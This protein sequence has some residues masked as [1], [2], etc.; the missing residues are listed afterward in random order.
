MNLV[1]RVKNILLSPRTEWPKIAGEAATV[2][3]LYT[4]YILILA[5]IAPIALLIRSGGAA[6]AAA[7]AQYIVALV[8]IYL[9]ALIADA[10]A[11]TFNGTKDFTQSL[12]LVAYSYTAPWIAGVFLLLGTTI[13]G[14]IGLL[15][16]IYAWYTFYLGVPALKKCPPEKAVGYT[17]VVVLCGI[18]LA[19]VLGVVLMSVMFGGTMG[20]AGVGLVR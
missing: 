9:L 5:A 20:G 6:I 13:G 4:G 15:A 1:D 7:I 12:K 16:A 14:L 18:V 11:P 2:Q 3:S 19:I 10:L 17:I 8:I